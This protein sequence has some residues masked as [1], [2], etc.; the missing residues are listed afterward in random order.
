M[1][2]LVLAL[3]ALVATAA[4]VAGAG[5]ALDHAFP[6]HRK[7]RPAA[8]PAVSESRTLPPFSRVDVDGMVD[9]TLIQGTE[10][11]VRIESPAKLRSRVG[12]EVRD[13]TLAIEGAPADGWLGGIFGGGSRT[14]RV[15]V[16]FRTIERVRASGAVT[17]NADRIKADALALSLTGASSVAI[18]RLEARSLTVSGSGA[19][20][21]EIAGRAVAQ[22]IEISGAGAYRAADFAT[23]ATTV[24]VSGAGKAIVNAA[25]TL[26]VR[27]SGAGAVDYVGNPKVHEDVSGAGRVRRRDSASATGAVIA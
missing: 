12:A 24:S 25:R 2:R 18:G 17:L 9:V 7:A 3:L 19:M 8:G 1:K 6:G 5:Y 14:A 20:K 15:V 26:D 13:G 16:T 11:A 23:D 21:A 10:E 22:T 4:V 27:I